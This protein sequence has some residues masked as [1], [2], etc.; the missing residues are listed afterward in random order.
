[1][2]GAVAAVPCDPRLFDTD[3]NNDYLIIHKIYFLSKMY[4]IIQK[5]VVSKI[6]QM[7]SLRLHLFDTQ[8]NFKC[9]LF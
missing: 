8:N 4:T 1:M 5:F 7:F 2:D 9:F 3:Q 6:F